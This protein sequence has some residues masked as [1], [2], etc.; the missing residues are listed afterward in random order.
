[1]KIALIGTTLFHQGA[2]YVLASIARGFSAHGHDVHI[3]LSALQNDLAKEH[4][5]WKPFDL[6]KDITVHI[7]PCRRARYSVMPLRRL[8]NVEHFDVVMNHSAPFA[9]PLVAASLCMRNRP[10]IIHVE[11]LGGVGLDE[12]GAVIPPKKDLLSLITNRLMRK[13]DAQFAVSDGTADAITRMT[14]YPRH[15]IY[16]VYNPV[17]DEIFYKKLSEEAVH[18]WLLDT[19]IPVV[20]AAGAFCSFKNHML[21]LRAWAKVVNKVKARLIIFGEGELRKNYESEIKDL[22]IENSVSLPGFTNNLPA[23]L[24]QACC[25]VV[26]S[27][28]ESFSVVLVEALASGTPVVSTNCPYGPPEILQDGKY[29]IL[30]E[31]NS[32]NAL[33]DGIVRAL[34]GKGITPPPESYKRFTIDAIIDRYEQAMNEVCKKQKG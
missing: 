29:G 20:I 15:K 13:F 31:N 9:L 30:V 18:P 14:G 22:G 16:T 34:N 19:S 23:A 32:E 33:A 4:P 17:I 8:M 28:I 26:S 3:I 7:L 25:F 11:H 10:K 6:S 2:E 27:T 1:M 5:D 24:K 21:L 12:K